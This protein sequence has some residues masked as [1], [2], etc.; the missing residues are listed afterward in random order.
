M[1]YRRGTPISASSA[2]C[3]LRARPC[4]TRSRNAAFWVGLVLGSQSEY[5]DIT[6]RLSFDDAKYNFL[7]A[8]RQGLNAGFHWVDG[9]TVTAP[10]LILE[11]LIPLA[12]VG[13]EAYVDRSEIDKYLGV[14]H[15][16]VESRGTGSDWM[17]SS[18]SE[19]KERGTRSERMTALTAAIASRQMERKPC[20]E[21]GP[22][23]AGR[24][25]RLD[26]GTT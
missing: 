9:E 12:R 11:T 21:W 26:P 6:E 15:D 2:V 17:M 23:A 13:L 10:K 4:W 14:I 20:H 7:A 5:G 24:S 16:R 18:L 3:C 1:E 25:G 19:M 22:G 8:S